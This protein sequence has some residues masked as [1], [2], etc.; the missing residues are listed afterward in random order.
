M[1]RPQPG[2]FAQGTR[3]HHHLE[4][5]IGPGAGTPAVAAGHR[6]AQ[7]MAEAAKMDAS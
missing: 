1:R 5:D 3:F 4:F 7:A 6:P 2:V